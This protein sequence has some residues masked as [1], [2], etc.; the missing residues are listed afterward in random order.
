MN[1][2]GPKLS[3]G[4][5]ATGG[6]AQIFARFLSKSRTGRLVAIGSRQ[7]STARA[8]AEKF[9]P[10]HAHGSYEALLADS[11]VQAVYL[12]PPHPF[13]AEWCIKAA[14][15]GKHILCE[16]PLTLNHEEALAVAKAAKENGVFL[17]EAFAYRCHPQTTKLV[18]LIRGGAIGEIGVIQV[19]NSFKGEVDPQSRLYSNAL[20]GGGILDV[21]CY[22]MSIARLVA[23]VAQGKPFADPIRLT[24]FAQLH[25]ELRTDLY[26]VASAQFPGGIFAQLAAGVGLNQ[27]SYLR[28]FGSKGSL[29]VPSPYGVAWEGGEST[30]FL[31]REGTS[32]S[33]AIVVKTDEWFYSLEADAVGDAVARGDLESPF[34]SVA[35]SLGNMAALDAWRASAEFVYDREK[36]TASFPRPLIA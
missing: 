14:R 16:K 21:G 24:G 31:V 35:D 11:E 15:A 29:Y 2:T 20:G 28:V 4:I 6:I 5:I 25:P 26:A 36:A 19:A 10:I 30:I 7:E 18:E 22:A 17:M 1:T 12:S 33:E 13:H 9:G 32:A 27:G 34:M 23:G 8:F 3:W